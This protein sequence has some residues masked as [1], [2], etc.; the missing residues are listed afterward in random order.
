MPDGPRP[1]VVVAGTSFPSLEIERSI[2]EPLGVDVVDTRGQS[3]DEIVAACRLAVGIMADYFRCDAERIAGFERCRVICQYGVGLDQID[4]DAAS[5]AGI[6]VTRTPEYCV[7]ELA[8]HTLALILAAARGVVRYDASVRKGEWDYTVAMPIRL[9]GATLGLVGFGRVGQAV[10]RRAAGFGLRIVA[11]DGYLPDEAFLALGAERVQLETLLRE[12][13]IVSVHVPLTAETRHLIGAAE[14]AQL[15]DG[16]IVVNTSR[17]EVLDQTALHE[18]LSSGR[19]AGVALDVLE[20]EPPRPDEPL[21]AR[22]DA[23]LTPHAGFLSVDSLQ[24]AQREAAEDV[25]RA[26]GGVPPKFCVNLDAVRLMPSL[27]KG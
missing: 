3:E 20:Q 7:D 21:V 24:R 22:P 5:R 1:T 19:L 15:R 18:A 14:L 25:A 10:A 27:R 23:V 13:D 4:V 9:S 26:L 2:L 6:R 17:G 12:S 16:A 11:Q 8:D